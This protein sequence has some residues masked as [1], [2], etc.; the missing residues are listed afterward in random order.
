MTPVIYNDVLAA[1]SVVAAVPAAQQGHVMARLLEEA[2]LAEAHRHTHHAAHPVHG[3]GSLMAAALRH[4][5]HGSTSFQSRIGLEAWLCVL[6][7][8]LR[9]LDQ[10]EAQPTHRCAVGSSSSRLTGMSSPQSSQ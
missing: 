5:R 4:D 2:D 9:R 10:P 7:A 1:V 8:L 3:D 6:T